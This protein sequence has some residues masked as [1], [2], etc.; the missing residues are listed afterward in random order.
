M[1]LTERK[2]I[3]RKCRSAL[4]YAVKTGKLVRQPC[5]V[6][7]KVRTDG[8]HPDYNK[9][10]SVQWLCRKHHL[11]LHVASRPIKPKKI[12]KKPVKRFGGHALLTKMRLLWKY[13]KILNEGYR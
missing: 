11:E 4:N 10:L 8:H 9:P 13:E 2:I 6:C 7:G 12:R 5:E 3:E 1:E